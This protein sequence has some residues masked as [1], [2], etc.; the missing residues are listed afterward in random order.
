MSSLI[1]IMACDL[2]GNK[3]LSEPVQTYDSDGSH[4]ALVFNHK[5]IPMVG[6]GSLSRVQTY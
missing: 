6:P 5:L 1:Y 3:P 2:I 4:F